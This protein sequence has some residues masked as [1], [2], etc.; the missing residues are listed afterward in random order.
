M[1]SAFNMQINW[2]FCLPSKYLYFIY[3]FAQKLI[4]G[5][6]IKHELFASVTVATELNYYSI[7]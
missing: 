1:D 2:P 4:H 7:Y 6:Y 5:F 3:F